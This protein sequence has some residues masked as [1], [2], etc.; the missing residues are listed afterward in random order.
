LVE[1]GEFDPASIKDARE[2]V[3]A[4]IVR[5]LGQPGFRKQLF[6]AYGA[7]CAVSDC[8]VDSVLEA[9][10]I[11]PYKGTETNDTRNGILLRCDLHTLFDLHLI[12]IDS[13]TMQVLVSA[14][15]AGSI[16][17]SYRGKTIRL[18]NDPLSHPSREA[19]DDHRK[20][21]GLGC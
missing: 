16:Y 17:E 18:P 10:H 21:S 3:L 11:V 12:A 5:R 20:K 19:L 15:L 13:V 6:S 9:A 2:R 8:E 14:K 4:S 7:R 1:Q